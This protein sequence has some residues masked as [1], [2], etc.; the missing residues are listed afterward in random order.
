MARAS[1]PLPPSLLIRS[2]TQARAEQRGVGAQASPPPGEGSVDPNK[3]QSINLRHLPVRLLHRRLAAAP[4]SAAA[5]PGRGGTTARGLQRQCERPPAPTSSSGAHRQLQG[6]GSRRCGQMKEGWCRRPQ[7]PCT[8]SG[9]VAMCR[10]PATCVSLFLA[11]SPQLPFARP[12]A[13]RLP[14]PDC[15]R[16]KIL[17]FLAFESL[18]SQR[19]MPQEHRSGGEQQQPQP[20]RRLRARLCPC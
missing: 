13:A 3:Q 7:A 20:T 6:P 11:R 12:A 4:S 1:I 8:V 9:T 19:S 18:R 2:L 15:W 16:F 10:Q 17:D 14:A 5:G